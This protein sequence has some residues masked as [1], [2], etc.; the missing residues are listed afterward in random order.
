MDS[1]N[2]GSSM[3]L[4]LSFFYSLHVDDRILSWEVDRLCAR[5][6]GRH[7]QH[8]VY[9]ICKG[10]AYAIWIYAWHPHRL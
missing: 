3:E 8:H 6:H 5:L 9:T 2:E 10:L 7:L 1:V 4:S